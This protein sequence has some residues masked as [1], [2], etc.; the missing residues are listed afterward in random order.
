MDAA[1]FL[2]CLQIG[3]EKRGGQE[4][5]LPE[6]LSEIIPIVQKGVWVPFYSS[7]TLTHFLSKQTYVNNSF[8]LES[9]KAPKDCDVLYFGTPTIVGN[10][11]LFPE[12]APNFCKWTKNKEREIVR[13]LCRQAE[14]KKYALIVSGLGSGD[15]SVK[16]RLHD[17]GGGRIICYKNFDVFEDWVLS[18]RIK[19][20]T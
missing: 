8:F 12:D 6:I 5:I 1:Y 11:A 10:K 20:E 3:I 18:R 4:L 15:I 13:A 7:G 9:I 17:M 19:N 14:I 16:E 2:Q